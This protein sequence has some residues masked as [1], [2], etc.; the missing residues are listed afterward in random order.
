[1]HPLHDQH[2]VNEIMIAYYCYPRLSTCTAHRTLRPR[3]AHANSN[4]DFQITQRL[5]QWW[6]CIEKEKLDT[7]RWV[8]LHSGL[9]VASL[10]NDAG[11]TGLQIAAEGDKHKALL[12]ILDLLRQKRELADSIDVADELGRT[13]LMIAASKGH[14]KS[15][16]HLVYYGA[17]IVKKS[18]ENKNAR[19]YA[20]DNKRRDV[21]QYFDDIEEE[22]RAEAAGAA[23]GATLDSGVDADGLTST[24]R[25]RLKKKQ[26]AE[27][28]RKA[29]NA[30]VLAAA[31]AKGDEEP[32]DDDGIAAASS[33]AT[34]TAALP[35]LSAAAP[36][37]KWQELQIA[38]AEKRREVKVDR[39]A[40][41]ASAADSGDAASSAAAGVAAMDISGAGGDP[42]DPVLY[43]MALLNR[44]ELRVPNFTTLSP[45]IGHLN[46]LQTLIL[47]G[48][49]LVSLPDT[50][51]LLV[52]LKALD[53]SRNA[54]TALPDSIAKLAKLE[55][56]DL[57][58][59]KLTSLAQ[60]APLTALLTLKADNN[61]IVDIDGLNYAGL[62]R[63]DTLSLSNNKVAALPEEIGQLQALAVLNVAD[64]EITGGYYT[65]CRQRPYCFL[66][67]DAAVQS[68]CSINLIPAACVCPPATDCLLATAE[69]PSGLSELK[70]KKIKDLRL[71]PNPIADKKVL[72]VLNKDVSIRCALQFFAMAVMRA[73]ISLMP[74]GSIASCP[75][76]CMLASH[77]SILCAR[78]CSV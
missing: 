25:S 34:S 56:L 42:V 26:M 67:L 2:H 18:R 52:D 7:V 12:V 29:M 31:A 48:N 61:E 55:V 16:D 14:V 75:C 68:I 58:D 62:A 21:V 49:A 66:L 44:L 37:A 64:N 73:S 38:I 77:P 45:M 50:I 13:P 40:A 23:S 47:S 69:L 78:P 41:A 19:D 30:A 27:E 60:L 65:Y 70:E 3:W 72:K 36:A 33:A 22:K 57:S 8:M 4:S 9:N 15:V 5:V 24:Q 32:E 46:S 28:A 6:G 17:S 1:M 71:L 53:V 10:Q 51:G 35:K 74:V 59:N 11:K 39:V 20:V 43:H 54:L 63:L 76:V